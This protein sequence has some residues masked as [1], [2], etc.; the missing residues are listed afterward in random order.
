MM[1]IYMRYTSINAPL[2]VI[3]K[4]LKDINGLP[5]S[6][7]GVIVMVNGPAQMDRISRGSNWL[8]HCSLMEMLLYLCDGA[9]N[10]FLGL[11]LPSHSAIFDL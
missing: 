3:C 8:V 6:V 7:S 1:Y 5:V 11:P 2:S 4:S 9:S 10:L